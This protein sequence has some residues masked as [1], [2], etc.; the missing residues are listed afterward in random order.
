MIRDL[1]ALPPESKVWIY[2][3]NKE[4]SYDQIDLIRPAIYEYADKWVSHG[5]MIESYGNI[6]HKRFLVLVADEASL[7]VSGCSIDGSVHFV[8]WAGEQLGVDFMG[9]M[10]YA[11][12][13][14]D[15]T[16][17]T[18][19]HN[20]FKEAYD[21]GNINKSTKV[22]NNLVNTKQLFLEQWIVP[23]E[24]SWHYKFVH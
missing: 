12:M 11:I 19:H 10:E 4:L 1:I 21:S 24:K 18:I 3:S 14:D 6:F 15:E 7:A 20:D 17:T 5:H 2:Q 13:H 8:K 9:R 22:F 23:L 16:I